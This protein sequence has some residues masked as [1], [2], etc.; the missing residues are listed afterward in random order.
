MDPDGNAL[1][2]AWNF[3]DGTGG[4]GNGLTHTYQAAGVYTITLTV[5]DVAGR[6]SQATSVIS[7]LPAAGQ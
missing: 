1:S 6:S 5:N 4:T 7:V 3:G 2:F